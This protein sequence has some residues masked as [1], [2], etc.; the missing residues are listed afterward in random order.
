MFHPT[1]I[2]PDLELL[3]LFNLIQALVKILIS[4]ILSNKCGSLARLYFASFIPEWN[5]MQAFINGEDIKKKRLIILQQT[6]KLIIFFT[7]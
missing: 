5:C 6:L 4:Y 2:F 7:K 3:G 1:A